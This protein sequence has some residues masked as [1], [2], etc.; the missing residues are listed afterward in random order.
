MSGGTAYVLDLRPERVNPE[1]V[2]L[3]ELGDADA[4]LVHRLLAR[5]L[6]ETDSAVAG[7]LL[8]DWA[9][10]RGRFTAV[11]P[12]DYRRVLDVR[13]AARD[14]G[15]DPDGSEVWPRIMEAAR[16]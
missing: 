6:A 10:S 14:A 15:L 11:V 5:H 3:S 12:R 7:R 9:E 13:Q 2:D 4:E 1:L 8:A 16:G